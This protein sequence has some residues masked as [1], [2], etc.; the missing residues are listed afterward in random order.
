MK[1]NFVTCIEHARF[2]SNR[3]PVSI[4]GNYVPADLMYRPQKALLRSPMLS[5]AMPRPYS[6]NN[7]ISAITPTNKKPG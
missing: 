7:I 4:I 1:R 6:D 3:N 2:S 5:L